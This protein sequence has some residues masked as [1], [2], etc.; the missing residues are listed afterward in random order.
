MSVNT[1]HTCFDFLLF[2]AGAVLKLLWC[3]GIKMLLNPF[4]FFLL[5]GDGMKNRGIPKL[6]GAL[7][8]SWF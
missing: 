8:G 1:T 2:A 5:I 3:K 7:L 6:G 4:P